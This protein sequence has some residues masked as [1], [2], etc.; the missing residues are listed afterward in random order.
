MAILRYAFWGFFFGTAGLYMLAG[1]SLVSTIFET[2][3][4]PLLYPGRFAAA[5]FAGA[6]GSGVEVTALLF[7]SG[8][9]YALLFVVIG[10]LFGRHRPT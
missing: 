8:I 2:V 10:A 6:D 4:K 3:A 5:I 1:L 7:F 9:F